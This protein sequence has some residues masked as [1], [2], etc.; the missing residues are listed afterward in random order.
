MTGLQGSGQWFS[1]TASLALAF[2]MAYAF[3]RYLTVRSRCISGVDA[4]WDSPNSYCWDSL[5][6]RKRCSVS[7]LLSQPN[8]AALCDPPRSLAVQ[9]LGEV[10]AALTLR[11]LCNWPPLRLTEPS[12]C[13]SRYASEKGG[14]QWQVHESR[15]AHEGK[16]NV[17]YA[18]PTCGKWVN[19]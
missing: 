19:R 8:T 12:K 4:V 7:A 10:V 9:L 18:R 16:M 5:T 1:A 14:R 13:A 17:S 15:F 6:V 11:S 3:L 2:P